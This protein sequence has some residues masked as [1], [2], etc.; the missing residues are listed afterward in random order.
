MKGQ[1]ET[2]KFWLKLTPGEVL[3]IGRSRKKN[4]KLR[5]YLYYAIAVAIL[6]LMVIL[7]SDLPIETKQ[8]LLILPF[9][10]IFSVWAL[11]IHKNEKVAKSF[12]EQVEREQH[13]NNDIAI[14]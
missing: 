2:Q 7:S 14:H 10:I 6:V 5:Q 9:V 12:L 8:Y 3:I 4:P 1:Q 11:I 13:D